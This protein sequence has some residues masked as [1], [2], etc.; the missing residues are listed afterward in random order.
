MF[1]LL[2]LMMLTVLTLS[3]HEALAVA[4]KCD[5]VQNPDSYLEITLPGPIVD[6]YSVI[7]EEEVQ[8]ISLLSAHSLGS[9]E[10]DRGSSA[11]TVTDERTLPFRLDFHCGQTGQWQNAEGSFYHSG[12]SGYYLQQAMDGDGRQEKLFFDFKNCH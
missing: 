5:I 2:A 10:I 6:L 12:K 1:T 3:G 9:W 4:Y 7:D 11:C 8:K